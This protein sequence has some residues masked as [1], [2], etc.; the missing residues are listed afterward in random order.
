MTVQHSDFIDMVVFMCHSSFG[1][2]DLVVTFPFSIF[3]SLDFFVMH[4]KDFKMPKHILACSN[5]SNS[6]VDTSSTNRYHDHPK[7][8]ETSDTELSWSTREAQENGQTTLKTA[9]DKKGAESNSPAAQLPDTYFNTWCQ[10]KK[11]SD[12]WTT[13]LIQKPWEVNWDLWEHC[14]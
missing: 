11:S 4:Q 6:Y 8:R 7:E 9:W 12:R 13:A 14:T 10:S 5:H 3:F 2:N 1:H